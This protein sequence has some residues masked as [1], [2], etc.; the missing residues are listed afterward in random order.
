[1][2]YRRFRRKDFQ[3]LTSS[4][5]I[6]MF[7]DQEQQAVAAVQVAAVKADRRLVRMSL[8]EGM[9]CKLAR[10]TT[11]TGLTTPRPVPVQ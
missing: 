6:D 2:P 10:L 4:Q 1:M 8:L 7:S 5:R 9:H 3:K 11:K